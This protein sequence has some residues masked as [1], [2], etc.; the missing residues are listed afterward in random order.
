MINMKHIHVTKCYVKQIYTT[1]FVTWNI[2]NIIA[3]NYIEH[4]HMTNKMKWIQVFL[5]NS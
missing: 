3:S 2:F 1:Q 5:A 4:A